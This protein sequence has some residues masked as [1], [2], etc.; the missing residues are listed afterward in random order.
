[1]A[2]TIT[3]QNTCNWALPHAGFRPVTIGTGNEPAITNANL[4]QQTILSPPFAWRWN[5]KT[6]TLPLTS[7]TQDYVQAVAD[8]GYIEKV[9]VTTNGN[10]YELSVRNCLSQ[11]SRPG[12]PV[13]VA[14]QT[15]DN[16]GNITFRVMP[17]PDQTYTMT[18]TYQKKAPLFAALADKWAIPDEYSFVYQR[19]FLSLYLLFIDDP[20]FQ[21]ENVKFV[22][23]LLGIA[24]GLDETQRNIFISNWLLRTGQETAAAFKTT[25]GNQARGQ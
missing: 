13:H 16:A 4:I 9:V 12:R 14:A 18:V 11:D 6:V 1:M 23:S 19:G 22:S 17:V 2:S 15:D 8:F 3:L 25:Q 5:R 10:V 21:V 7:G 24:E 20:K